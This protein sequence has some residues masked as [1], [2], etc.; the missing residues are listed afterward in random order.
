MSNLI[1]SKKFAFELSTP[2]DLEGVMYMAIPPRDRYDKWECVRCWVTT[3]EKIM[4]STGVCKEPI[5]AVILDTSYNFP[6]LKWGDEVVIRIDRIGYLPALDVQWLRD[7][8]EGKIVPV[9]KEKPPV[10]A[11][12]R[13]GR[14][15]NMEDGDD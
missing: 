9:P 6:E 2:K 5:T 7:V 11:V 4:L 8:L 3:Y 15:K 12:K 1:N 13:R 10:G 14:Q